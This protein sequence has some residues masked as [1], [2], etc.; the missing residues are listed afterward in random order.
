MRHS[1]GVASTHMWSAW[2]GRHSNVITQREFAG[3]LVLSANVDGDE[4]GMV[5]T[6]ISRQRALAIPAPF[7]CRRSLSH[8]LGLGLAS[9]FWVWGI[10]SVSDAAC[11]LEMKTI[12]ATAMMDIIPK[13]KSLCPAVLCDTK[14][15]CAVIDCNIAAQ[16]AG[17]D[18]AWILT[19]S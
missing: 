5:V 17:Q 9:G 8:G 14:A 12:T 7:R 4:S 2:R 10:K 3:T 16:H 11:P 15:I 13:A 1:F 18:L 6:H 19:K